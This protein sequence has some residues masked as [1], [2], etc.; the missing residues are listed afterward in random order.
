MSEHNRD[1]ICRV[2][3][4]DILVLHFETLLAKDDSGHFANREQPT[5]RL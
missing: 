2:S 3:L 1:P 5:R 4:Q